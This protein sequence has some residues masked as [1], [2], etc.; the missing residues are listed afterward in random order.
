MKKTRAI[1]ILLSMSMLASIVIP[2]TTAL[3]VRADDTSIEGMNINK[4][5]EANDDGTYTVSLEAYATGSK[6]TSQIQKDVPTDIVLV[7][8]QSGSMKEPMSYTYDY[9]ELNESNKDIYDRVDEEH[10][11]I[12]IKINDGSYAKVSVKREGSRN[13]RWYTY[14]WLD[15][16]GE[17]QT[18]ISTGS[19]SY[20]K[21]TYYLRTQTSSGITRLEAL[22][23]AVSSFTNE[24]A[25]KAAGNDRNLGTADDVKH[26]VA[27]VGFA[28]ESGYGDNTE[29]LSIA[30][31]NSGSVGVAYN[32]IGNNHLK[33]V[34][35]DMSTNAGQSMVNN[36]IQ[37]LSAEGA[38]RAD[39]GMDMAND[40]LDTNPVPAG[41]KRNRVVVFFTDGV[42]TSFS[43]F[44]MN[45]ANSAISYA[46]NIKTA[47]AKVYSVGIFEG[48]NANSAGNQNGNDI[49]KANWFMQS[50]SS[51]NGRPQDPSFYLSAADADTLNNIF[52]QIA[53]Q[54]ESG[55]SSTTLG[56][57]AVIKDLVSDYFQLPT[58]TQA[59]DIIVQTVPCTGITNDVPSWG[60]PEIFT[61]ANVIVNTDTGGVD[62]SGF[63]F[64]GNYVGMDELNGEKI[65]HTPANKLCI[66]FKV[67]AK[68]GFLGG[69]GVPTNEGAYIYENE[70]ATDPVL[71]FNK[72]DVDVQIAPVTVKA[73]DKNVYLLGDLT[74]EQIK[75]GTTAKIGDVELK[76][77]EENYGLKSWQY[78]YVNIKVTYQD[79]T[80]NT[81]ADLNDL[82][83]DTTYTVSVKVTPKNQGT[84]IE[85]TSNSDGK[86]NVFK[87]ELTFQDSEV[88]YGDTE[89]SDFTTNKVFE[90]WKHG[91]KTSTD[92]GII[93]I[94]DIPV[95]DMTYTPDDSQIKDGKV[96]TKKDVPVDVTVK[97]G[98]ADVTDKTVFAHNK[99]EGQTCE[100]PEEKEF[101]LH[102]KTC[103]LTIN[104]QGGVND[105]PY[106][107]NV[108]KDGKKYTEVTIV[109][110]NSEIIYELPVGTYTI[111]E[112]E[113]WSWRYSGNNGS[114]AILTA[115]NP[116][117]WI[118]CTNNKENNC[119][120]NGFSEVVKNIFGAKN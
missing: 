82:K 77:D 92:Q 42:P 8:D 29:L 9:R 119:W 104:K 28:S 86:I 107:F 80:G 88:Y 57:E 81:V 109:G 43:N 67:E 78:E 71:E 36:A 19:N 55:G 2:C 31:K 44:D 13:N 68:A 22:K 85:Q 54:I 30:G 64:A 95:L 75:S 20:P 114:A 120:L 101:L 48:A 106:V 11:E 87:P 49:Q 27:V 38:T 90:V 79:A 105:E 50:V 35:Q 3:P 45:V 62:V 61:S 102:V 108:Y 97:I 25:R 5:A 37:A 58:G 89:P 103:Q 32:S 46:G 16:N 17:T 115:E 99:C 98:D 40:I 72:P 51:N 96:N 34:L 69:N 59:S 23:N 4:T 52:E 94:G 60:E 74:A 83:E 12:F 84:V 66:S 93:M 47:G 112:D 70:S 100:L 117:S 91:G 41:E 53:D 1:S 14:S 113:G 39:L 33:D 26:R 111:E 76:L 73:E 118:T 63:D 116:D 21:N 7:L 56:K 10:E 65:L 110:N 18:E 24:V 6:F 15:E